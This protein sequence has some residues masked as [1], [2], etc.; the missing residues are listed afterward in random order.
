MTSAVAPSNA[1]AYASGGVYYNVAGVQGARGCAQ[2]CCERL[3][4]LCVHDRVIIQKNNDTNQQ[5]GDLATAA[6]STSAYEDNKP[7]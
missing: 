3:G 5:S 7:G 6:Y 2:L 1:A 4:A